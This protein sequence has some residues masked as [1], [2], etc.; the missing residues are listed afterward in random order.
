MRVP[1]FPVRH[2]RRRGIAVLVAVVC[3]SIAAAVMVGII[4]LALQGYRQ[5]ELDERR[6]QACWIAE[7]GVDLAAARLRADHRYS[8]ENWRL[9][10]ASIGGRHD[11]EVRIEVQPVDGQTAWRQVRVVADYPVDLPYRVR[12]TREFRIELGP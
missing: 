10:A 9:A 12:E 7:S 4:H 8:G 6:T 1:A 3:V 5:A 11:A 2:G